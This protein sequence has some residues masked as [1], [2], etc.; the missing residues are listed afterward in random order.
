MGTIGRKVMQPRRAGIARFVV[1]RVDHRGVGAAELFAQN[2][3]AHVNRLPNIALVDGQMR[4]GEGEQASSTVHAEPGKSQTV[5]ML[6][7]LNMRLRGTP[8]AG[9]KNAPSPDLLRQASR[10]TNF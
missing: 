8:Q 9:S 1:N 2:G 4:V 7:N 5:E 10:P 6:A 3:V